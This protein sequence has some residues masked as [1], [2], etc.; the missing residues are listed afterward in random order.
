MAWDLVGWGGVRV[1][2]V[3]QGWCGSCRGVGGVG[4]VGVRWVM[5][6][7]GGLCYGGVG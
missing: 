4:H 3:M 5:L 2:Y 7:W 6:G 1:G